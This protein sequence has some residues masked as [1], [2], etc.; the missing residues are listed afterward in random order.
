[1]VAV[2]VDLR[3]EDGIKKDEIE[4]LYAG[5]AEALRACFRSLIMRVGD[6]R[7]TVLDHIF[8]HGEQ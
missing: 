8:N 5:F 4:I 3:G 6:I 1:M 7:S 2:P